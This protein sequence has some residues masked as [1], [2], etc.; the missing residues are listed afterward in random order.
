MQ[1]D[2]DYYRDFE[3]NG[4]VYSK[5]KEDPI[6]PKAKLEDGTIVA[7]DYCC[8]AGETPKLDSTLI[9]KFLGRGTLYELDGERIYDT[10]L[11][12]PTYFDFWKVYG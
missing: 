10:G 1:Q 12:K 7:Y 2:K 3:V 11:S 4:K 6:K 8:R 5:P 9:S